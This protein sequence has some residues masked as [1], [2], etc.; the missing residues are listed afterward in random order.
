MM[1]KAT[2]LA[3]CGSAS[4]LNI[5]PFGGSKAGARDV[6]TLPAQD[7]AVFDP[8]PL[9]MA[10]VFAHDN[11]RSFLE[12]EEN[13]FQASK[14]RYLAAKDRKAWCADRC[15][16]TGHCDVLE[17]IYELTTAQ[18]MKFCKSCSGEDE[19]ELIYAN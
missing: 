6:V 15:L 19:C 1:M 9:A 18:V 13:P 7:A 11:G 10:E 16:A 4:A 14:D 8:S 3:L 5:V 2:V 17:D 12:I